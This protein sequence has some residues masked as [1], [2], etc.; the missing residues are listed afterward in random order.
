[1]SGVHGKTQLNVNIPDTPGVREIIL[2]LF[3]E[4]EGLLLC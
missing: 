4:G 2:S 1:M 3:R